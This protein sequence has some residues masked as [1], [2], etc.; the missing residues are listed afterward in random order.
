MYVRELVEGKRMTLAQWMRKF[1]MKHKDYKQD[2]IVTESVMRDLLDTLV[3]VTR[4]EIEDQN[5]GRVFKI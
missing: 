4:G 1:V 2:S 5:F 3:G